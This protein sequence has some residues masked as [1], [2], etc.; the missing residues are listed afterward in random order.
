[1][2]IGKTLRPAPAFVNIHLSGLK[3]LPQSGTA[4]KTYKKRYNPA[5]LGRYRRAV[6]ALELASGDRGTGTTE[7]KVRPR[8][9]DAR[10]EPPDGRI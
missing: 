7:Q 2:S 4:L 10:H 8:H 9:A 3:G 6:Q 5:V 1:M